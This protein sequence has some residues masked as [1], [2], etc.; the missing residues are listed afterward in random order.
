LQNSGKFYVFQQFGDTDR[1]FI[2]DFFANVDGAIFVNPLSSYQHRYRLHQAY[3]KYPRLSLLGDIT[4]T[5]CLCGFVAAVAWFGFTVSTHDNNASI[6][7]ANVNKPVNNAI[8]AITP[9]GNNPAVIASVENAPSALSGDV[10]I[11]AVASTTTAVL[12]SNPSPLST[13]ERQIYESDWIFL[14]AADKFVIQFGSSSD[15]ALVYE[16]A[17]AFPTGPIAVYPFKKTPSDKLVYGYSSG[18]YNSLQDAQRALSTMPKDLQERDP[19]IRPVG[20]L[21]K[22][23]MQLSDS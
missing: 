11:P 15:R 10:E 20:R 1:H 6:I 12:A 3:S 23:I 9:S 17:N 2:A 19:W 21:Q 5:A 16:E 18:V 4:K 22:R 13:E 7:A 8:D 14:L